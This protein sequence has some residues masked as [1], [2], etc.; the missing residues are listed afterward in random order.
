MVGGRHDIRIDP[1][2]GKQFVQPWRLNVARQDQC[3]VKGTDL[4]YN[5]F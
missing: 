3:S 5:T 1:L 2:K 4:D